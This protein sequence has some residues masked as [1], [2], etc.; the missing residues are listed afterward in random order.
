MGLNKEG[1]ETYEALVNAKPY[2]FRGNYYL[3]KIHFSNK[4]FANAAKYFKKG[5][6]QEVDVLLHSFKTESEVDSIK[7]EENFIRYFRL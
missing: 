1:V 3:G 6:I 7:K 5:L 4:D 2:S